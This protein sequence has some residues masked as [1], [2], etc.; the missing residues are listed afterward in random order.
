MRDIA[1]ESDLGAPEWGPVMAGLV[2]V[3][4]PVI[5][6]SVTDQG[7]MTQG[8]GRRRRNG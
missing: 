7:R 4:V 2:L 3:A 5:V 6:V 8:L 1:Q